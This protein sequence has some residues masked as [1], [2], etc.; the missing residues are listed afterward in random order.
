MKTVPDNIDCF[1]LACAAVLGDLHAAFP[2]PV[3]LDAETVQE[4]LV[5]EGRLP[6][7]CAWRDEGRGTTLTAATLDY[8][9]AEGL[10]R[11]GDGPFPP[12]YP[13]VVLTARGFSI[14]Q[15]PAEL[16]GGKDPRTLGRAL[17]EMGASAG[18]AAI[19]QTIAT[20]FRLLT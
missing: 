19:T 1:S 10:V 17:R 20:V 18:R 16:P 3:D 11:C 2:R 4:A 8:L 12:V 13:G 5:E 15:S 7:G 6:G 9:L 14:L